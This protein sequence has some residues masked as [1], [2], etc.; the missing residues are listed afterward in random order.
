MRAGPVPIARADAP[1][2]ARDEVRSAAHAVLVHQHGAP[3]VTQRYSSRHAGMRLSSDRSGTFS[4]GGSP[5]DAGQPSQSRDQLRST[6]TAPLH[7]FGRDAGRP[8]TVTPATQLRGCTTF[9]AASRP[10]SSSSSAAS[11][12][13]TDEQVELLALGRGEVLEHEVG[14]VLAARGAADADPHPQ[15]VLGAGGAG[16]RAQPV[17]PALAAAALEP[18]DVEGEVELVVHDDEVGR[19][20]GRVVVQQAA[21][22]ARR[23]RSCR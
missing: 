14:G 5:P 9:C 11:A 10:R 8:A 7:P 12:A 21:A 1:R 22:P 16:D 17:V 6:R 2:G 15:V 3:P 23:T 18:D 19:R 4:P 20:A 13:S